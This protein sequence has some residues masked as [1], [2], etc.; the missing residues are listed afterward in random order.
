M[1]TGKIL[2][3]PNLNKNASLR[4]SHSMSVINERLLS[5]SAEG[6]SHEVARLMKSGRCAVNY[7]SEHGNTTALHKA[8]AYGHIKI[9]EILLDCGANTNMKDKAG[10]SP[11][12]WACQ[13]GYAD[14]SEALLNIHADVNSRD[15]YGRTP[16][17]LAAVNGR[18]AVAEVLLRREPE[19][20][21]VP[22]DIM[23][24]KSGAVYQNP[25]KGL[26]PLH[27]ACD[28]GH[29]G[30]VDVLLKAK[31]NVNI[32]DTVLGRTPLHLAALKGHQNVVDLLIKAG[33][34][35][36]AEADILVGMI[37]GSSVQNPWRNC[38]PL[39]CATYWGHSGVVLSL[40]KAGVDVNAV[41]LSEYGCTALHL[42]C[43]RG[44]L[45]VVQALFQGKVDADA[46]ADVKV[47]KLCGSIFNNSWESCTPLHCATF[48][49]HVSIVKLLLKK[50]V[51]VYAQD[52]ERKTAYAIAKERKN[53]K[54]AAMIMKRCREYLIKELF[55]KYAERVGPGTRWKR[56]AL[57]LFFSEEDIDKIEEMYKDEEPD[58]RYKKSCVHVLK[59]WLDDQSAWPDLQEVDDA[60]HKIEK[61]GKGDV[62]FGGDSSEGAG[63]RGRRMSSFAGKH[64]LNGK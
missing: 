18:K 20:N 10:Y 30:V 51:Q 46:K 31:I 49:G 2:Q 60:M 13:N 40:V 29:T 7:I 52:A 8:A 3:R 32:K 11:L 43:I 48:C 9:V 56:L 12:H 47:D 62:M 6:K 39:M 25:W 57:A 26:T 5:A 64:L 38:T 50:K 35:I 55:V 37:W 15:K 24:K 33:A 61:I 53:T 34:D 36:N 21:A 22:I 58:D 63:A 14:V 54:L 1:T 4:E 59:I 23:G 42:A 16:L 27:C 41:D 28:W 45:A 19:I 44:H 17:H